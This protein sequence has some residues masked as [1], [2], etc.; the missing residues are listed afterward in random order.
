MNNPRERCPLAGVDVDYS[1]EA[2]WQR[3]WRSLAAH[4]C[5]ANLDSFLDEDFRLGTARTECSIRPGLLTHNVQRCWLASSQ[6][7]SSLNGL[8]HLGWLVFSAALSSAR[9]PARMPCK[10]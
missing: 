5:P 2:G 1:R 7:E 6:P 3:N 8:T 10:P 4:A 9:A